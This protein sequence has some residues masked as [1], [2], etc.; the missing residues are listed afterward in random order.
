V[1]YGVL[2]CHAQLGWWRYWGCF[3]THEK[4]ENNVFEEF[5]IHAEDHVGF[6]NGYKHGRGDVGPVFIL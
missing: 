2:S 6:G 1:G 5:R 4:R 3:D